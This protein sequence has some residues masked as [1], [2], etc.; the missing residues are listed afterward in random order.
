MIK[1]TLCF[2]FY[3]NC[4]ET[5]G[6]LACLPQLEVISCSHAFGPFGFK[7][8]KFSWR[9]FNPEDMDITV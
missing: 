7:E 4:G 6:L 8:N 9:I 5:D 2:G 3:I 1:K